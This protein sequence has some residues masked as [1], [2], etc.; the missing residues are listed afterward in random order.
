MWTP[1]LKA[2]YSLDAKEDGTFFI[3][4]ADYLKGFDGTT[5]NHDV[6]D[7][8]KAE[9]LMLNDKSEEKGSHPSCGETCTRHEF[10]LTSTI[11]Q[12][13]IISANLWQ[14][15]GYPAM[16]DP[17]GFKYNLFVVDGVDGIMWEFGSAML[18]PI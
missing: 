13:V 5:I 3:E 2:D 18:K 9:F 16:C 12:E 8:S 4:L 11:D 7:W 10:T 17:F 1:E 6:S 14:L 15:R